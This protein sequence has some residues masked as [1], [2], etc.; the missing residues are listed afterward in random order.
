MEKRFT[1]NDVLRYLYGEMQP[2]EEK[3]FLDVLLEDEE[4]WTE[5]ETLKSTQEGLDQALVEP[6]E[7]SLQKITAAAHKA[8]SRPSV[9]RKK[10]LGQRFISLHLVMAVSLVLVT[11]G[12]TLAVLYKYQKIREDQMLDPAQARLRWDNPDLDSRMQM[13]KMNI[14]MIIP[15]ASRLEKWNSEKTMQ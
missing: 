5:F 2:V 3:D 7:K 6:S 1:K 15:H 12:S 11:A 8:V 4:L 13:V 9:I 14:L 10:S